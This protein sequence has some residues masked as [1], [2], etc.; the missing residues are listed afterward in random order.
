MGGI[1]R[2]SIPTQQ[3]LPSLSTIIYALD[4]GQSDQQKEEENKDDPVDTFLSVNIRQYPSIS[5]S[6]PLATFLSVF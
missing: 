5:V 2:Y 4:H 6:I 1:K 3:L